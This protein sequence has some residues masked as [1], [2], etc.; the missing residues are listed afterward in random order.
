M[1]MLCMWRM[2]GAWSEQIEDRVEV[3]ARVEIL[4]FTGEE[5]P[6]DTF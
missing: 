3:M 5:N 4:P 2:R 1:K 6:V